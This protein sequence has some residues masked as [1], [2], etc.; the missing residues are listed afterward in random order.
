ME[1]GSEYLPKEF[2]MKWVMMEKGSR[3]SMQVAVASYNNKGESELRVIDVMTERSIVVKIGSK[4][5]T[6]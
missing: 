4:K 5:P 3:K 6:I 2:K 1:E